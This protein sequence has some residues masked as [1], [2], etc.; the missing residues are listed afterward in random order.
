MIDFTGH[1]CVNCRKMEENVWP[2]GEVYKLLKNDYVLISLYVDEKVELPEDEQIVVEKATG[3]TRKLRN[4][5]NK[6]SHFQTEYFNTN[7]QP[8]YV[9]LAPNGKKLNNPVGY[10]PDIEEYSD[11]LK[12][13]LET[14]N[15]TVSSEQQ[16]GAK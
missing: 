4:Y 10:T 13:G 12:C 11:F 16:L 7:T 9:L 2:K 15:N 6:W 1:A 3:G 14:F 8:Y 5:G